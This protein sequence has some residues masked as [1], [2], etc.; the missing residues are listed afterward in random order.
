M[1][2]SNDMI[3]KEDEGVGLSPPNSSESS[4]IKTERHFDD[5][6][7]T[8]NDL[9]ENPE[10][11]LSETS[12][13]TEKKTE[14]SEDEYS[15]ENDAASNAH[16]DETNQA[17]N[18]VYVNKNELSQLQNS[19]LKIQD[20]QSLQMKLIEQIQSQLNSCIKT[21][22]EFKDQQKSNQFVTQDLTEDMTK[23]MQ[24]QQPL[25]T[26]ENLLKNTMNLEA[27]KTGVKRSTASLNSSNNDIDLTQYKSKKLMAAASLHKKNEAFN[28]SQVSNSQQNNYLESPEHQQDNE[29]EYEDYDIDM[30]S[31]KRF[32]L[33][34]S[35]SQKVPLQQQRSSSVNSNSSQNSKAN[36]FSSLSQQQ[37]PQAST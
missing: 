2:I 15:D 34:N 5:E 30:K 26:P 3:T 8:E 25:L 9:D 4:T 37:Q 29:S 14:H 12:Q 16:P 11:D 31:S 7:L 13:I 35:N 22:N 6:S 32:K 20:Q 10:K 17:S 24:T 21:Q 27:N 33:N 1:V 18:F 19:I 28:A 23:I 36:K